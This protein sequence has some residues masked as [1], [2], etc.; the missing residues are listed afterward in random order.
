MC[1]VGWILCTTCVQM[2]CFFPAAIRI[3]DKL[4]PYCTIYEP[5]F[6]ED[7][8]NIDLYALATSCLVPIA[9]LTDN[10]QT[11]RFNR[12]IGNPVNRQRGCRLCRLCWR[13]GPVETSTIC[14]RCNRLGLHLFFDCSGCRWHSDLGLL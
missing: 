3:H 9:I 12:F 13:H 11:H 7:D 8:I 1:P 5:R 10:T 4:V 2:V 14:G 6:E